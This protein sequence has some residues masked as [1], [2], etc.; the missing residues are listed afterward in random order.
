MTKAR[1]HCA[2]RCAPGRACCARTRP[3]GASS[4]R[5]NRSSTKVGRSPSIWSM[6]RPACSTRWPRRSAQPQS[7]QRWRTMPV[8]VRTGRWPSSPTARARCVQCARTASRRYA[9][10]G[11]CGVSRGSSACG[12]NRSPAQ[13]SSTRPA[14][15]GGRDGLALCSEPWCGRFAVPAWDF[16]PPR[17]AGADGA[18]P[19]RRWRGWTMSAWR[20]KGSAAMRAAAIAVVLLIGARAPASVEWGAPE[21]IP[22]PPQRSAW[23]PDVAI[24]S[25]GRVHVVYC[26]TDHV[27]MRQAAEQPHLQF[28][29]IYYV[30]RGLAGWSTPLAIDARDRLH[31]L[32][33]YRPQSTLDVYY[34]QASADDGFHT[35]GWQ[36]A[37]RRI[38]PHG[39]SYNNDLVAI[40]DVL[41]A[42]V[43]DRVGPDSC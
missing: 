8:A 13:R 28:E 12:A 24:D 16:F 26:V 42:V 9:R 19:S 23:F 18:A 3:T 22:S 21:Q 4:A 37:A 10:I 14:A 27:L 1:R 2:M 34:R 31:L 11:N 41:H 20:G 40:G 32:L 35:N 17:P 33:D 5:S 25:H 7:S 38:N 36:D 30:R 39:N 15:G 43:D 6:P 29:D